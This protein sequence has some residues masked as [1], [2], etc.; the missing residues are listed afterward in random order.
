MV[1]SILIS[2]VEFLFFGFGAGLLIRTMTRETSRIVDQNGNEQNANA[3]HLS[4]YPNPPQYPKQNG[5]GT[6]LSSVQQA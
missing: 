5:Q 1:S 3:I 4:P 2:V 6:G